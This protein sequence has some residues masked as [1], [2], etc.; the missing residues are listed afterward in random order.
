MVRIN[1]LPWR[2]ELR[3]ERQKD[4]FRILALAGV[5]AAVLSFLIISYYNAQISGQNK[6]NTYLK[7][8]VDEVNKK[9]EEIKD[10]HEKKQ[11]LLARKD[12][13]EGLQANRSQ[14]VYLFDL[15][16]RTVPDGVVLTS[17]AQK[18]TKL[19]LTGRSQSS[20]RVSTYMR[21]LSSSEWINDNPELSFIEADSNSDMAGLPYMFRLSV[22]LTNPYLRDDEDDSYEGVVS[23]SQGKSVS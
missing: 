7:T 11:L 13:I 2:E 23:D 4:F 6:R 17:I 3:V 1:L 16:V 5:A 22:I 18:D 19:T 8:Q 14:M 21:S 10:I 9:T 15:L 12:V 20:A